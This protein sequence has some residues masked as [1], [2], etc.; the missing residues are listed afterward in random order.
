MSLGRIYEKGG[1]IERRRNKEKR[2]LMGKSKLKVQTIEKGE[3]IK[4]KRGIIISV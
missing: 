2:K 1:K 3:N 4:S